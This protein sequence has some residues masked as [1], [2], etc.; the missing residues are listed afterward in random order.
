M[1]RN[2]SETASLFLKALKAIRRLWV[3]SLLDLVTSGSKKILRA[4][5]LVK[6]V[7]ILFLSIKEDAILASINFL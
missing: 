1:L 4:F 6:V 2:N 7:L 3:V 5:A